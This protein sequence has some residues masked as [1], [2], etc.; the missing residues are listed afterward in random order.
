MNEQQIQN[1]LLKVEPL[2]TIRN[3]KLNTQGEKLETAKLQVFVSDISSLPSVKAA[4]YE[5]RVFCF[6]YFA[7]FGTQRKI[8]ILFL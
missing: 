5:I 1:L 3:K 7:A 2:S 4:I 8:F 6:A